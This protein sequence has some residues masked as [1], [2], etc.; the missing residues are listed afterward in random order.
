MA[1]RIFSSVEVEH[2]KPAPDIFL[3]AARTLGVPPGD[4]VVIEDSRY[5]VQAARA[6][7][8]HCFAFAAGGMTPLDALEGPGTTVFHNM[9]ALPGLIASL[10]AER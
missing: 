9:H 3:H 6:A 4:C 8:M 10:S 1:G 5:G 7:G 2:G